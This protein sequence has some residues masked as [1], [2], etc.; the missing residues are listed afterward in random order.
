MRR[1]YDWLAIQAFYDEGHILQECRAEFGFGNGAW[2]S[3]VGRGDIV[4]RQEKNPR[5]RHDTRQAVRKLLEA[6]K[7]QTEI[8]VQLG[9]SKGT[10][11]YHARQLG[12]EGDR[13]YRRRYDWEKIQRAHA[14]GMSMRECQREFGFS[15]AAWHDAR[16]RGV[17]RPPARADAPS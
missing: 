13:R 8:A 6:G 5:F 9:L 14:S 7:S 11:C 16:R 4:P 12:I 1:K 10:I 2:D 3:A 17:E 15:T